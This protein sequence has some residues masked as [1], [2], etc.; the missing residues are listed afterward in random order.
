LVFRQQGGSV[1]WNFGLE[2]QHG[3]AVGK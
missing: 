3:E 2:L 1:V